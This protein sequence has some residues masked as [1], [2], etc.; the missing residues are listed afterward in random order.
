MSSSL[1][2]S[3]S[4]PSDSSGWKLKLHQWWRAMVYGKPKSY[5]SLCHEELQYS[6]SVGDYVLAESDRQDLDNIRQA[7]LLRAQAGILEASAI[8]LRKTAQTLHPE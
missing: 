2:L 1:A 3:A 4:S 7:T 8:K 6:T 5:I